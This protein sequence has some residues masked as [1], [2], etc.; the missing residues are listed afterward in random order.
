M[1]NDRDDCHLS[2]VKCCKIIVLSFPQIQRGIFTHTHTHTYMYMYL[3]HHRSRLPMKQC[4]R[5]TGSAPFLMEVA[6]VG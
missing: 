6:E 5:I 1:I 4:L 3:S 2:M